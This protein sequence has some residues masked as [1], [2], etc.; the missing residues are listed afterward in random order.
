MSIK[1]T[2]SSRSWFCVLNNPQ[3]FFGDIE[4]EEMVNKAIEL[5][6]QDK[7]DRC[8]AINFEVGTH[9]TSHMHMVLEDPA[10]TRFAAVQKLFPG[11]HIEP[12]RGSKADAEKYILKQGKFAEKNHTVIVPAVFH[13]EIKANQG[14]RKDLEYIAELLEQGYTPNEIMDISIMYR[15][16]ESLI[17]RQYYRMREKNT[18]RYR[19][20]VV[21]WHVGE[22][23]SGKSFSYTTLCEEKGAD[24]VYLLTDYENGGF[25]AYSAES[26]LFLDEF[27]GNFRFQL[28]LNYLDGYPVQVHC[29]YSNAYALW[30]EVHITSIYPPEE[31]YNF[32]VEEER[33]NRDKITQLKRRINYIVYHYKENNEYKTFTLPMEEYTDYEQLKELSGNHGF[34]PIDEYA[35]AENPFGE[36]G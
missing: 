2:D 27:K 20:V 35:Q 21:F 24:N 16:Y 26:V 3:I 7:P 10:K 31:V 23:G 1:S 8:C 22:S 15:R 5:W 13:G 28:L 17:K 29:R 14:K 12:T 36:G 4:P 33:R 34:I 30:T 6:C 11:I 9:G 25:D 19:E 18:P 32:M